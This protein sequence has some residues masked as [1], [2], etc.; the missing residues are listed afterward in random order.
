MSSFFLCYH[1]PFP[2]IIIFCYRC[3]LNI[4]IG[5]L[6]LSTDRFLLSSLFPVIVINFIFSLV[7][8]CYRRSSPVII[9]NFLLSSFIYSYHFRFPDIIIHFLLSTFI[10]CLLSLI[11]FY[12]HSCLVMNV[13]ILLSS[14]TP[15]Y[16]VCWRS[17][18]IRRC[19]IHDVTITEK[20]W[21]RYF[22]HRVFIFISS[23]FI[24]CHHRSFQLSCRS[25]ANYCSFPQI[26]TNFLFRCSF[27]V[28]IVHFLLSLFMWFYHRSFTVNIV[29]FLLSPFT[30]L[31]VR[32]LSPSLLSCYHHS[33]SVIT[34]LVLL[35]LFIYSYHH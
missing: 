10:S 26:I 32:I 13:S 1:C 18:K 19:W 2:A 25:F 34:T 15:C 7:I 4:V 27:P 11:F 16:L 23:T 35:S 33:S 8:S 28:I 9:I 3:L 30:S 5:H 29:H 12:H 17:A 24:F 6:L 14:S 21:K 22:V 31:I 20:S